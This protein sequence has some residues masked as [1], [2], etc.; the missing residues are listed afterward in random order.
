MEVAVGRMLDEGAV[1]WRFKGLPPQAAGLSLAQIPAQR[2]DL[3]ASGFEWP[4][5]VLKEAELKANIVA[6]ADFCAQHGLSLAPHGKTAMS[7][8]LLDW[9]QQAGAWAVTVATP[10]Q[11]RIFRA[12]GARRILLANELVQADFARWV[13]AELARDPDFS[14]LCYVDSTAGV[15]LLGEALDPAGPTLSVLLEI[16][17]AGGRTGC[18]TLPC[19]VE[20]ATAVAGTPGLA[21][22][23]VAGYEGSITHERTPEAL[24]EVARY[25]RMLRQALAEFGARGLLDGGMPEHIVTVGGSIYFDVVAAELA[26]G[27]ELAKPVRVV[28]RSG[29]YASHDHDHYAR[30]S[31]L[32]ASAAASHR[33]APAIEVW[34]Q[35]LSVPE[36]GLVL[37]GAGRRD[38]PDDQGMPV[39]LH[40]R[41][42]DGSCPRPATGWQIEQL[43]DQ[44]AF[45]RT[46]PGEEPAVAD[47]V[48]LGISHPCT[49]HDK[50]QVA[51]V[52][53]ADYRVVDIVRSFF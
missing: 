47:L 15:R 8:L 9:Q 26:D 22:A 14:F 27:W 28:T 1:G 42:P 38:L 44:H 29:A 5:M 40:Y 21:L 41:A 32:G 25:I 17:H 11:A 52:V 46:P 36:S 12:G 30:L 49:A 39:P 31:P 48:C 19:A 37:L 53:D 2:Y 35:V 18:R 24:A 10:H 13:Q 45:V 50:W 7:P 51:P 16:G 3:F 20:V 43:N 34:S 6:M 33:L 4:V 23:G